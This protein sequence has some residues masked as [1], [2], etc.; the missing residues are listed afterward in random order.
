MSSIEELINKSVA[1]SSAQLKNETMLKQVLINEA[2]K[3]LGSLLGKE[4]SDDSFVRPYTKSFKT[5][6]KDSSDWKSSL[7]VWNK[8]QYS[9]IVS[10]LAYSGVNLCGKAGT[11]KGYIAENIGYTI[12]DTNSDYVGFKY[13]KLSCGKIAPL[14]IAWGTGIDGK[15]YIGVILEGALLAHE[16][17]DY[18]VVVHLDEITRS[19]FLGDIAVLFDFLSE[20]G[21]SSIMLP[22]G[23]EIIYENNLY[24]VC[25]SND[26]KEYSATV[27]SDGAFNERFEPEVIVGVLDNN[28]SLLEFKHFIDNLNFNAENVYIFIQDLYSK[29]LDSDKKID[30]SIST[31]LLLRCINQLFKSGKLVDYDY[32]KNF[33]V[34]DLK[35]H[36]SMLKLL[37]E[38]N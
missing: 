12:V 30:R 23:Q 22:N 34:N 19:D 25:T 28:E 1:L 2:T 24:I 29:I 21:K 32:V 16:N 5:Y 36:H 8:S 14:N 31:R 13:M 3:E 4:S 15:N 20:K 11:G 7:T 6:N 33:L 37:E 27:I 17:P 26:G 9:K 18:A 10:K 35:L 38:D